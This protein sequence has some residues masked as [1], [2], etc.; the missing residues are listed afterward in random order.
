MYRRLTEV[1]ANQATVAGSI[2][3]AQYQQQAMQQAHVVKQIADQVR[4]E[5]MARLRAGM[6]EARLQTRHANIDD[7]IQA[8]NANAA[9]LNQARLE[10]TGAY[11]TAQDQAYM[12]YL[13]QSNVRGQ[14]AMAGAAA[15]AGNAYFLYNAIWQIILEQVLPQRIR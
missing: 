13:N 5:R 7:N 6:S 8:L 11:L 9:Q 1:Y 15:D 2:A 14:V 4:N 12:D 10:A 3:E